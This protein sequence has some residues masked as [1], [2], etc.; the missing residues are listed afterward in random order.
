MLGW[1]LRHQLDY[2]SAR[3]TD[4]LATQCG[5]HVQAQSGKSHRMLWG[6]PIMVMRFRDDG[7]V[8]R[9][10]SGQAIEQGLAR[11]Q[12]ARVGQQG[13]TMQG[14]STRARREGASSPLVVSSVGR[15]SA[16]DEG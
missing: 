5:L 14:M 7:P 6:D 11:T 13:L 8:G 1:T 2:L 10:L 15:R 4:R 9:V 16:R 3:G 12:Q